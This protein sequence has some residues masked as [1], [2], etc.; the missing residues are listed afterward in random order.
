[1]KKRWPIGVATVLVFLVV[2]CG[3]DSSQPESVQ[4]SPTT[5][6]LTASPT[7]SAAPPTATSTVSAAASNTAPVGVAI[8]TGYTEWSMRAEVTLDYGGSGPDETFVLAHISGFSDCKNSYPTNTFSTRMHEIAPIGSTVTFV[9]GAQTTGAGTNRFPDSG[10][11]FLAA[12]GQS[13]TLEPFGPSVNEMLLA[14]GLGKISNPLVD[15]SA[16]AKDPVEVQINKPGFVP[17]AHRTPSTGRKCS[18]SIEW[19]GT[20]ALDYWLSAASWMTKTWLSRSRVTNAGE[21]S[22]A[23]TERS[24]PTMTA[25]PSRTAVAEDLVVVVAHDGA[26][27]EEA[28]SATHSAEGDPS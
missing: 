1:M 15:L 19:H 6:A 14:E 17:D 10:F 21:L 4:A 3:S 13:A 28:V 16:L 26:D 8:V 25:T 9:R 27:L 22:W 12:P 11:M 2:R 20:V 23:L 24:E 18:I 7:S 5:S